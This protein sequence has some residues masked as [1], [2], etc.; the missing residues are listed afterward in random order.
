MMNALN[1]NASE[2]SCL[3]HI[4]QEKTATLQLVSNTRTLCTMLKE[5]AHALSFPPS[6]VNRSDVVTAC[7]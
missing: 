1:C 2:F 4:S 6:H 5:Q 3:A 7:G